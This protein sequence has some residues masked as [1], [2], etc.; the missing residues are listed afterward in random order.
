MS[1]TDPAVNQYL[2]D[3]A[4]SRHPV[5]RE[6]ERVAKEE[7]FPIIG[8]LCGRILYQLALAVR[9]KSVFE[10]GSGYGYSAFWFAC[11]VG[12]GGKVIHTDKDPANIERARRFMAEAGFADRV[13]F[14]LGD[15]MQ[16]IGRH[17]GPFDVIFI[18][19]G[20]LH[21]PEALRLAKARLQS[22]G[23]IIAD[24]ALQEG[25]VARPGGEA[26]TRAVLEFTRLAY[27]DPELV[28]TILPVRDG[29]SVS[30]KPAET[31]SNRP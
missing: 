23:L 30:L 10:M 24:D 22:G 8:P 14:E 2:I 3:Q 6:M 20:K 4:P 21:Y 13:T 31:Q 27:D 11:A 18:D 16:T 19:V 25:R 15:A 7:D 29:L 5:L 26:Q 28:T 1:I 12:P 9:A 17:D